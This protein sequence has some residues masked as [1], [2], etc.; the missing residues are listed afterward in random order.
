[1][2]ILCPNKTSY[3][4]PFD[5]EGNQLT[6]DESGWNQ[7]LVTVDNYYFSDTIKIDD[8]GRGRSAATF[9]ATSQTNGKKYAFFMK[10]MM[11]VVESCVLNKGVFSGTF[12]FRKQGANYSISL[13]NEKEV[14]ELEK[15]NKSALVHN[16]LETV[17][18]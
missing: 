14:K 13:I 11:R 3:K 9:Y 6:Y 4:I 17:E 7:K 15:L 5:E 16:R 12:T 8:W 10:E 2:K 1:M 18:S